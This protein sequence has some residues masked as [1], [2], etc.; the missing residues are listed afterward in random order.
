MAG[1]CAYCEEALAQV[2]V[3]TATSSTAASTM[4]VVSTL[5]PVLIIA[6]TITAAVPQN[7]ASPAESDPDCKT[8]VVA[9]RFALL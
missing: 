5:L 9:F 1:R 8:P 4:L 3:A 6:T 2:Y 7:P